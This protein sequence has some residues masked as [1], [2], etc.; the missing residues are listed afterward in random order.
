MLFGELVVSES[1]LLVSCRPLAITT[2]DFS[3]NIFSNT[4]MVAILENVIQK[5]QTQDEENV[6]F[7]VQKMQAL[8]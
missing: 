7:T 4:T 8:I 6:I 2:A 5:S 1:N 3:I